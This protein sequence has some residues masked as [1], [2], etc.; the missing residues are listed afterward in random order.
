MSSGLGRQ[1]NRRLGSQQGL[2]VLELLSICPLLCSGQDSSQHPLRPPTPTDMGGCWPLLLLL[3]TGAGT[4]NLP[5]E[6]PHLPFPSVLLS[7][8]LC[9]LAGE[10]KKVVKVQVASSG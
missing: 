6:Y 2:T 3:L 8:A 7:R 1:E 10:G 4:L 5:G 9:W